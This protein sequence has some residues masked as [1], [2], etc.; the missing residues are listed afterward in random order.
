MG[1]VI[2]KELIIVSLTQGK[3]LHI[4]FVMPYISMSLDCYEEINP[5]GYV[6][7][8]CKLKKKVGT[9][10]VKNDCKAVKYILL[11]LSVILPLMEDNAQHIISQ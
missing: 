1:L 6:E 5:F 8:Y 9:R 3:D 2:I 11:L 4:Y 7:C 10:I